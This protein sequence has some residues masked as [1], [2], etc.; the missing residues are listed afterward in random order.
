MGAVR[1]INDDRHFNG[2]LANAGQKLVV[3]DFTASWCGPCQRI[4][5]IFEQ[6][7]LKYPKAVFLKVDVD[8]CADTASMQDVSAMPT[9]IFYRRRTRLGHCQGADPVGLESKIQ[10]FYGS[11]DADDADDSVADSMDLSSFVMKQ[12]C[13]CLNESDYHTFS[14]CLNS[15]SGY[16]QSDEDEQLIMSIAFS[17]PVKVHSLKIKA[18]TENGPKNIKLFINQPRTI[19]FE[20]ASSNTSI[21][22]L[23]LSAKDLEE[24]NPIPLRYV[25]FQNVQNL[26][27]F[28]IDNQNG[29][30]ITRIDHLVI[31][32]SPISTTN[33]G[34]FK[35]VSGKEG[36]SH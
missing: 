21:Q 17:Q 7:S 31:I 4:A 11:G 5:P 36:E 6:L 30:E 35:R 12:Q 32:G 13:E 10:Q 28:V 25:K 8:K 23:T 15:D 22:D 19:D 33:M 2:E 14:Q 3:V 27:I 26:Q 20:M 9:F 18:P 16:L 29:S 34:E 24:G 1:I